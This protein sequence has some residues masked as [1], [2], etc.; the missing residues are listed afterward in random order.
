MDSVR[1]E[2]MTEALE[3]YGIKRGLIL[4]YDQEESI[5]HKGHKVIVMPVWKWLLA[6]KTS[7]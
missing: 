5:Q 2:A 1:D 7:D 3:A 4:T 6:T